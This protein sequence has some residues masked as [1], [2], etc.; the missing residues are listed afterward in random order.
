MQ[1]LLWIFLGLAAGW[2]SGRSLEGRGYGPSMDLLMGVAGAVVGGFFTF[3]FGAAG[4]SGTV[5]AAFV[6]V[7]SAAILTIGASL[8]TGKTVYVRNL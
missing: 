3:T 7:C 8:V 2:L 5:L 4:A 1:V 6:A